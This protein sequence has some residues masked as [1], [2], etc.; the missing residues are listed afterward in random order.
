ME[1]V[2]QK[3][4]VYTVGTWMIKPGKEKEFI[5]EWSALAKW[6]TKNI[7]KSHRHERGGLMRLA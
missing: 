3:T 2:M 7:Q 1:N 6:T 4:E 5:A